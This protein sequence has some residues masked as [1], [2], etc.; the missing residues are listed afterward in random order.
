MGFSPW[1]LGKGPE[2]LGGP[3]PELVNRRDG[4]AELETPPRRRGIGRRRIWLLQ[5]LADESSHAA[6]GD[7]LAAEA[8][9]VVSAG[10][11]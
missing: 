2:A 8:L 3:V 10:I 11:E 1:R 4:G 5:L 6:T 7:A 9:W